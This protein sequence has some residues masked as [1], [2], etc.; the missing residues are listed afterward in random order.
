MAYSEESHE[1]KIRRKV[2]LQFLIKH[3]NPV[4]SYDI[5]LVNLSL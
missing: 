4:L 5:D 1:A 3:A 2:L